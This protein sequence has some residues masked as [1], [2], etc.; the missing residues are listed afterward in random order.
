MRALRATTLFLLLFGFWSLLSGRLD[1]LF[2]VLGLLS[3][4]AV[5]RMSLPLLERVIGPADASPRIHLWYLLSYILWLLAR[6]PP[7]GFQVAR[8]VLDP[9]RSPRPG[10]VR[11]RTGLSTPIART[12]LANSITLV[13]G[14][15]TIEVRDDL[16][17]VHAFEPGAAAELASAETQRRIARMFRLELDDPPEMRWD[18]IHDALPEDPS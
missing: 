10:V 13:P 16:L 1:P 4:A 9:R 12:V 8:V 17:L 2:I 6:I 18:P 7:A 15:M 5:T 14:T 11:F 3:A